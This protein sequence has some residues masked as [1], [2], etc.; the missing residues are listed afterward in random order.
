MVHREALMINSSTSSACLLRERTINVESSLQ[1]CLIPRNGKEWSPLSSSSSS[2]YHLRGK[3]LRLQHSCF[4]IHL[5][6]FF[7]DFLLENNVILSFCFTQLVHDSMHKFQCLAW[8]FDNDQNKQTK[9]KL[10][11]IFELQN[12]HNISLA[13][14]HLMTWWPMALKQQLQMVNL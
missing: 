13:Y 11:P 8:Q 4:L 5:A 10:T 3:I 6:I 1:D 7:T 12:I 2:S 9:T 14:W